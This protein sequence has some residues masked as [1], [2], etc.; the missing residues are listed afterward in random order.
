MVGVLDDRSVALVP[1]V[2]G[3][4][5]R[6]RGLRGCGFRLPGVASF[7]LGGLGLSGFGRG[8]LR[9]AFRVRHAGSCGI[10]S[11][12]GDRP[13]NCS[14]Q[15]CVGRVSGDHDVVPPH[16]R[17]SSH[18]LSR[19]KSTLRPTHPRMAGAPTVGYPPRSHMCRMLQAKLLSSLFLASLL[20]CGSD[21]SAFVP[22]DAAGAATGGGGGFAGGAQGGTSAAGGTNGGSSGASSTGTAGAAG[23]TGGGGASGGAGGGADAGVGDSN[24]SETAVPDASDARTID[25]PR[26]V[27][28][29]G[30]SSAHQTPRPLGTT[31][32]ALGYYEYL[33]PGY[34]D[35]VKRPIL[36]F[37]HGVGENGNGT[38]ELARVPA[39]GPP[40]LIAA[41]QWPASRP[42]V[43]LSGQHIPVTGMPDP[44]YGGFDCWTPTE[45][46]DFIAFGVANYD[47]DVKR[48]YVTGLSCGAMGSANYFK[49]YGTQQGITAAALISGNA[50]IAWQGQGCALVQQ[51]PLWAFHGDADG[52]VPIT[53]DNTAMPLFEACAGRKDVRYTVY[54]GVNHDAWT[55][56][57]D[58]SAGND[59]YTW[60]LGFTR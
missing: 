24:A 19:D 36:F 21:D 57:Y 28:T 58:L 47:I 13:E 4:G 30:P 41:D 49:Q 46:F 52:T 10:R 54:P 29:D 34:G 17:C 7:R 51:M 48:I 33:P 39:N 53:G 42:F 2:A 6:G 23:N 14:D 9:L 60:F 18:E 45:V 22:R 35:G 16:E 8:G 59:I 38:T 56:T 15:K 50:N 3:V 32:A 12:A 11:S 31:R 55:R 5:L 20:G 37:F 40:K 43:V 1:R 44:I 25:A 26:D 27:V